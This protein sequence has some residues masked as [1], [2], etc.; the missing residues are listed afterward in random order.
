MMVSIGSFGTNRAVGSGVL[1]RVVIVVHVL[2]TGVNG[3]SDSRHAVFVAAAGDGTRGERPWK[4]RSHDSRGRKEDSG[5]GLEEHGCLCCNGPVKESLE[6]QVNVLPS[7][8]YP[9]VA[10]S[11]AIM[12]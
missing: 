2:D 8:L 12:V 1:T 9:P 7:P 6:Q 10:I 5:E 4:A 11:V 3:S